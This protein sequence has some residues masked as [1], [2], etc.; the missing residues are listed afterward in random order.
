MFMFETFEYLVIQCERSLF[1]FHWKSSK[2]K[3]KKDIYIE[4]LGEVERGSCDC[5]FL[6][7]MSWSGVLKMS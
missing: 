6:G 7:G 4:V 3:K 2:P 5:P 1:M